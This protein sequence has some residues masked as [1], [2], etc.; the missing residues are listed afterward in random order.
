M[1]YILFHT[2][3]SVAVLLNVSTIV[4]VASKKGQYKNIVGGE[5][6]EN[7]CKGTDGN[8]RSALPTDT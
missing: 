6:L 3:S 2:D 5:P 1:A 7:L 4:H 8:G